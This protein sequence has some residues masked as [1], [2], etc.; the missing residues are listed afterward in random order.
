M[1]RFLPLALTL[2]FAFMFIFTL[3]LEVAADFT[4]PGDE[5]PWDPQFQGPP[6]VYQ[7]CT[8]VNHCGGVGSG[9]TAWKRGIGLDGK[10]YWYLECVFMTLGGPG[11]E[12]YSYG[13]DYVAPP[14]CGIE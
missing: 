4:L 13:C 2:A 7:C 5:D 8:I 3:T 1:K 10:P 12:C 9:S 14:T 11:S 6:C